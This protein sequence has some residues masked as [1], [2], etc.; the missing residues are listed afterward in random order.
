MKCLTSGV[1]AAPCFPSLTSVG[2]I[3][4]PLIWCRVICVSMT[5]REYYRSISF[6]FDLILLICYPDGFRMARKE[7]L[8]NITLNFGCCDITICECGYPIKLDR[9]MFPV[10]FMGS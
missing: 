1:M 8:C 3:N 6:K 4:R 10:S 7:S 9:N 5:C 2:L